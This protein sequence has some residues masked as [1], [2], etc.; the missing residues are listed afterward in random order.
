MAIHKLQS[1]FAR[2]FRQRCFYLFLSILVLIVASPFLTETLHGR[3]LVQ[4]VQVLVLIAS[5]AAVG[6]T[7]SPFVIALLLGIPAFVFQ[8][9]I[10]FGYGDPETVRIWSNIFHATFY[11]VAIV[12]LLRYVFSS[13]VMTDDKLFGAASVYLMIAM[14]FAYAY[15]LV[16]LVDPGAF[17]ARAG[18]KSRT[19]YDL[20]YMSFGLLTSNG[21]GDLTPIG[22]K[23]RSIVI[24][25]QIIG[26]LYVA[27]LIARLAGIYPPRRARDAQ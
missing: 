17:G 4:A 23:V 26:V 1:S 27:I 22:A 9:S 18:D 25:E 13:D 2:I 19:F 8:S 14:M 10:T 3:V 20:L 21:P 5:V 6:R 7:T 16:Q 12:Y 24:V 11:L 15:L